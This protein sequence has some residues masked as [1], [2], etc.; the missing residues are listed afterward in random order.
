MYK[1]DNCY[2]TFTY[3]LL[4]GQSFLGVNKRFSNLENIYSNKALNNF[5]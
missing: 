1:L 5:F 4:N 2:N 3:G